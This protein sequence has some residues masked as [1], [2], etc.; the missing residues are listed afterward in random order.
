MTKTV[1]NEIE[2]LKKSIEELQ[3]V[4]LKNKLKIGLAGFSTL[5]GVGDVAEQKPKQE[6]ISA[7]EAIS[8]PVSAP[9][10][11]PTTIP[12]PKSVSQFKFTNP[13]HDENAKKIP[14]QRLTEQQNKEIYQNPVKSGEIIED[15]TDPRHLP[16]E[17][18]YEKLYNLPHRLITTIRVAGEMSNW[19]QA[20]S[21]GTKT[22]YQFTPSTRRLYLKKYGVDAWKDTE[23]SV[24][25]TAL[26]LKE[27]LNW[28]KNNFKTKNP[29][30]LSVIAAQHFH[31]GPNTNNW[32]SVNDAYGNRIF[33][34]LKILQSDKDIYH[35]DN[36]FKPEKMLETISKFKILNPTSAKK[37]VKE[38]ISDLKKSIEQLQEKIK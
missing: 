34:S 13:K 32:G 11:S 28:A 1:E 7:Q 9:I 25:A 36:V 10:P 24:H 33:D 21:L 29:H 19:K 30:E 6:Q 18:H 2:Q 37:S 26:H 16:T 31:G 38:E 8:E 22:T 27:S 4:S 5:T 17:E 23:N 12:S 14:F 15:Y 20:S 35:L 3:K